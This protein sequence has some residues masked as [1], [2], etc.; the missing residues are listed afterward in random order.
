MTITKELFIV[1]GKSAASTVQQAMHKPTQSVLA[2]QGKLINAAKA[3]PTKVLANKECQ[4]LFKSLACGIGDNCNPNFLAFAH[5]IILSDPDA[6]GAHV[7][8]LLLTL[9]DYYLR[10]LID[11][12]RVYAII[13]PLFRVTGMDQESSQ[14][15]WNKADLDALLKH[16]NDAVITRF[17]GIA[18][19][20]S[21]E[22]SQLLLHPG[23]RKQLR[24]GDANRPKLT[25]MN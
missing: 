1:E 7:R 3:S 8:S 19:F 4:K 16:H 5:I 18:Q 21:A 15:A 25:E 11:S 13:P 22:C 10:E 17:K 2:L 6:D 12:G 14:Y 9:F 24:I 23:T 20:S